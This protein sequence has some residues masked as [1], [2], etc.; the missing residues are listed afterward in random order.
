MIHPPDEPTR[1]GAGGDNAIAWAIGVTA[2][3]WTLLILRYALTDGLTRFHQWQEL[4]PI[5]TAVL[6]A[7]L[8]RICEVG[9]FDMVPYADKPLRHEYRL[10]PRGMSLWP[11]MATICAWE[12]GWAHGQAEPVPVMVHHRCGR[13]FDPLMACSTCGETVEP[14]EVTGEFGP[15]GS[16][17]RSAPNTTLR[18]RSS[19]SSTLGPGFFPHTRVLVGNRWSAAMMGAAYLGAHRFSEF[20]RRLGAPATV[21]A[22]RLRRFQAIGVL[23][24]VDGENRP[25]RSEYRL[26]DKGRAFFPVV[27]TAIEWGQRWFIAPEG[28]AV[29]FRHRGSEH[30]FSVLL[31]CSECGGVLAGREI[32]VVPRAAVQP[33]HGAIPS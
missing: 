24:T 5:S 20:Q 1:L 8:R 19:G 32:S 15:S 28:P 33:R 2:D 10:T 11:M 14:R 22:D 16:W 29:I 17:P 6:T 18:R 4:L 9:I 27:M 13:A 7:R 21:I 26:T 23:R 3:E 31:R 25:D 12:G 30:P